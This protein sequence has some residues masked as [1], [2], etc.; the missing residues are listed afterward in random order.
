MGT[1]VAARWAG[2]LPGSI[3]MTHSAFVRQIF[4]WQIDRTY[5][6]SWQV[7]IHISTAR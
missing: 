1:E 7:L 4:V 6:V 2:W 5:P 3:P